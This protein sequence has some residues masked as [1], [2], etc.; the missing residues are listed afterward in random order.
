MFN[1][2]ATPS[3]LPAS[4]GPSW[5]TDAVTGPA[6][7]GRLPSEL[8]STVTRGPAL[9]VVT[10]NRTVAG[11]V[12]FFDLAYD[13]AAVF[14]TSDGCLWCVSRGVIVSTGVDCTGRPCLW[15]GTLRVDALYC[16]Q[17]V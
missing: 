10:S 1:T 7:L 12:T 13:A 16:V 9:D 6:A 2:P 3:E 8:S 15:G 14:V 17:C 4:A 11:S 5:W